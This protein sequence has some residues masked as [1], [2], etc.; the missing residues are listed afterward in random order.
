VLAAITI[1]PTG[2]HEDEPIV[3]TERERVPVPPA[4]SLL[5]NAESGAVC[6]D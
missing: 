4:V 6:L 1:C 2:G 3:I 5:P